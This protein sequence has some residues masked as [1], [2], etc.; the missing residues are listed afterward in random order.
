ML[1]AC[2]RIYALWLV[3]LLSSTHTIM[4]NVQATTDVVKKIITKARGIPNRVDKIVFILNE[5]AYTRGA[6]IG[7]WKG[8]L[9]RHV[10]QDVPSIQ[11]YY[12]VDPWKHQ[13]DWNKPFNRDDTEFE[14]IYN[15]AM[16]ATEAWRDKRE[17]L[18]GPSA[19]MSSKVPNNSLDFL[20][21]DGDHTEKG[22]RID[23]LS[24]WPKL[25]VGGAMYGDD[26]VDGFQHGAKFAGT[27]VKSVVTR[28][29]KTSRSP[30]YELAGLQ[31]VVFKVK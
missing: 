19:D 10:L 16:N 4:Y 25:R 30:L 22:T 23:V 27:A 29:A 15:I 6:E 3:L 14:E 1:L 28:F 8:D 26:F 31:Y 24:W 12:L 5:M 17:V 18:R 11:K 9:A 2:A 20:Y 7:V 13:R 21:I